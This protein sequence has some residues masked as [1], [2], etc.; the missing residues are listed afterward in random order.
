MTFGPIQRF[1]TI[2]NDECAAVLNLMISDKPLSGF[3]GGELHGGTHVRALEYAWQ[4][5][6]GVKH[7]IACNSATSGLLAACAAVGLDDGDRFATTPYTM[8]ATSACGVMLGAE[9]YYVDV[10]D[11]TFTLNPNGSSWYAKGASVLIVTNLFGHPAKLHEL[12]KICNANDIFMIEDN[13]QAPFAK[14]GDKYAGTIGHIGVFS[15]NVHKHIQTGEGG[16]CVTD[17]DDLAIRMRQFIN[18]GE[19]ADSK[20][21]GLNLRMTEPTAAIALVQLGK[22]PGIIDGRK[23]QALDILDAIGAIPNMI[24]PGERHGCEHVCYTIPFL[25]DGDRKGFCA[26][27]REEGIPVVEGYQTPLYRLPAFAE[28]ARPCPVAE[29]LHD[30]RL[31]LLENCAYD[32]TETQ[33]EQIGDAFR[34][35]A[36]RFA[37]TSHLSLCHT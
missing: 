12:R 6:F 28:W 20:H 22:A 27:L 29:D 5:V 11:E 15:L 35:H 37:T 34:K 25:F 24:R 18:H 3:L 10:E 19:M 30:R 33:I 17:D 23:Q 14:E 36:P 9:P 21:V 4:M 2:H 13:A 8:S 1:N 32:F 26:A 16:I 31:F 7:A